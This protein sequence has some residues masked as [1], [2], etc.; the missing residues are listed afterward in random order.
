DLGALEEEVAVGHLLRD[1][2]GDAPGELAV[3]SGVPRAREARLRREVDELGRIDLRIGL[4]ERRDDAEERARPR[5][6]R[7]V[8]LQVRRRVAL[9]VRLLVDL[10]DD[11]VADPHG[12]RVLEPAAAGFA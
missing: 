11:E 2:H 4:L 10:D 5:R 1:A 6:S 3:P 7:A 8:L 12:A 9:G